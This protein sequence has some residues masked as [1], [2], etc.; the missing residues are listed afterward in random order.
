M[1][2]KGLYKTYEEKQE[3][4]RLALEQYKKNK[5]KRKNIK[6][7]NALAKS[8]SRILH[9]ITDIVAYILASLG[10]FCLL[11]PQTKDNTLSALKE[12]YNQ[13]LTIF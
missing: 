6:F 1:E 5:K 8:I 7:E 4:D 9:L 13:I 12:L 11:N 2:I 10:L 3:N